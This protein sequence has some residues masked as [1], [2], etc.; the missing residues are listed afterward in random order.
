MSQ[1]ACRGFVM[2]SL[3]GGSKNIRALGL[4]FFLPL[5]QEMRSNI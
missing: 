5:T 1:T 4:W 3:G 2:M